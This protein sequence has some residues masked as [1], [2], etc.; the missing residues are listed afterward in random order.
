MKMLLA[1]ALSVLGLNAFAAPPNLVWCNNCSGV[2]MQAAA[3]KAGIGITYVGDPV[4]HIINAYQTY[5]DVE[6]T[7]PVT[8][9]KVTDQIVADREYVGY[10]NT[11]FD[12]YDAKPKGWNKHLTVYTN[13]PA[14]NDVYYYDPDVNVYNIINPGPQQN[15]FLDWERSINTSLAGTILQAT[16]LSLSNL[17]FVDLNK[18]NYPTVVITVKF[19][20]NSQVDLEVDAS[21]D[22]PH[23]KLDQ[24]SARDSHNNNVPYLN[25]NGQI[26]GLGGSFVF[27][28][29]G[30]PNDLQNFLNEMA[31]MG[32]PITDGSSQPH[33][34]ACTRVGDGS[35]VCQ[36]Y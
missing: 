28:G 6:D 22:P 34:W 1:A 12:F 30:N 33:G 35:Y 25:R 8:R 26:Q 19:D 23:L 18:F 9:K 36:K 11:A 17:H 5:F 2:Q 32:V 29:A 7:V 14:A 20:D 15:N 21:T 24:D 4:N 10:I 13:N 31:A 3:S 16:L 27:T